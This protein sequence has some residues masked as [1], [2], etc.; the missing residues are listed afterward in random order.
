[1]PTNLSKQRWIPRIC[2][3]FGGGETRSPTTDVFYIDRTKSF[4]AT[5]FVQLRTVGGSDGSA[6]KWEERLERVA[7]V[8]RGRGGL[9]TKAN[10]GYRNRT[11][12]PYGSAFTK[13]KSKFCAMFAPR[14]FSHWRRQIHPS[15]C[16]DKVGFCGVGVLFVGELH[17]APADERKEWGSPI[18]FARKREI[19]NF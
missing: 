11:A 6:T 16:G 12:G 10:A 9:P 13:C 19:F 14:A 17:E 18:M 1:M 15:F 2:G 3:E 8:S 5:V 7:A 4:S